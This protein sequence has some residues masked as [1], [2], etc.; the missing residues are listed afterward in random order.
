MVDLAHYSYLILAGLALAFLAVLGAGA[1]IT[2]DEAARITC[3]SVSN[4][5][6]YLPYLFAIWITAKVPESKSLRT[7]AVTAAI[8]FRITAF[9][10]DP[11]LSDDSL[12]YEWEASTIASGQNPYRVSPASTGALNHR[13]PGYDFSAVYGPVLELAHWLTYTAKLPLKA[14]AAFAEGLLLLL[15]WRCGWP[16]WQWILLA[17]SPLNVYE[18]WMNGHNDAWLMLLLFAA[19]ITKGS[20]SWLW[21]G[22]ATLTK[23]WPILLVP[24]WIW[25]RFSPLGATLYLAL[26]ASCL[27]LMPISEWI[28]KVRFTTGFLGGWQN[29]PFLYRLLTDKMQAVAIATFTSLAVPFLKWNAAD[30]IVALLTILLAFSANIHP[31]Y[32]GWLLPFLPKSRFSPLPWLLAMALLPL[33]YDPMIGWRL[34]GTWHEDI[35]LRNYI[36]GSVI[37][38][39]S[40]QTLRKR[41]G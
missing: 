10:V 17:W 39:V 35:V 22:L 38:F 12:R 14:S 30:S 34:N 9:S 21:L 33:A 20:S 29:N 26:L 23:W 24:I 2:N 6:A 41:N 27:F 3:I 8:L 16:L 13:I 1:F 4:S 40:Y 31:W 37:L 7:V 15:A 5:I 19:F 11:V 28:T 25:Q 18:F 32:L 36:W